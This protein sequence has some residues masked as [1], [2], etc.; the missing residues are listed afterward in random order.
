MN[1]FLRCHPQSIAKEDPEQ[2]P[3]FSPSCNQLEYRTREFTGNHNISGR[4]TVGTPLCQDRPLDP[5]P[6]ARPGR[7]YQVSVAVY[8]QTELLI[9]SVLLTCGFRFCLA[10]EVP[11]E[12]LRRRGQPN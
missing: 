6:L 5:S 1:L 12:L 2:F 7:E 8:V 10:T 3:S 9:S 11:R 4:K